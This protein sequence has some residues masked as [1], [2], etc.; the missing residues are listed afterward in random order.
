MSSWVLVS[1][2]SAVKQ[3]LSIVQRET[4]SCNSWSL[5]KGFRPRWVIAEPSAPVIKILKRA[6]VCLYVRLCGLEETPNTL[7]HIYNRTQGGVTWKLALL[8]AIAQPWLHTELSYYLQ[9]LQ[10]SFLRVTQQRGDPVVLPHAAGA[11]VLQQGEDLPDHR[12]APQRTVGKLQD[13]C[14]ADFLWRWDGGT[15]WRR[16][17][18]PRS[19][20]LSAY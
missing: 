17:Y 15:K 1:P 9:V 12:H 8:S 3:I 7:V 19:G 18:W 4:T 11:A 14:V 20:C 2:T 13:L 6:F 5:C 16:R 10:V